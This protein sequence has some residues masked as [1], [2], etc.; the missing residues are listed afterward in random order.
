MCLFRGSPTAQHSSVQQLNTYA[1]AMTDKDVSVSGEI[2]I[3]HYKTRKLVLQRQHPGNVD[4][5][6]HVIQSSLLLFIL[7]AGRLSLHVARH[8]IFVHRGILVDRQRFFFLS[9]HEL[10][11]LV[12]LGRD[13]L[14]NDT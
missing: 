2:L 1:H 11:L 7:G 12:A 5:A 6:R 10:V 4:G 9:S 13:L 3:I 8:C 14:L